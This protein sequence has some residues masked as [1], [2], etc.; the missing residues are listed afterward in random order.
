MK[1][2]CS[3]CG[4]FSTLDTGEILDSGYTLNCEHCKKETIIDL[5]QPEYRKDLYEKSKKYDEIMEWWL[6][7]LEND[8][9]GN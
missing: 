9:N 6:R 7:W 4:N 3:Q 5:F 2:I 1:Y 8:T